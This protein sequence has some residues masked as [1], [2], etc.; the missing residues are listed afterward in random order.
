MFL[1][2]CFRNCPKDKANLFNEFFYEQ[3]SDPS[4]YDINIDLTND[5]NHNINFSHHRIRK[6]LSLIN[7]NKSPGPD[8]IHGK[9]LKN[10][11]VGLSYPLSLLFKK[12]YD[13]GSIPSEWKRAQIVPVHKKGKKENIENYRPIS[14]TSLVMKTF[15]RII[16]DEILSRTGHLLDERQH[17]F[18]KNKSCATNLIGL[19]DSLA[20]SMNEGLSTDIV[21]FDFAK[22]FD[23]VS[24]DLILKKLKLQYNIDGRL[25]RFIKNYLCDREQCVMIG[26]SKSEM[27]PVLSGVP[28]GSIIGPILFVLFIND[29]PQGL[30]PDT[31]CALYADDTKIWRTIHSTADEQIVQQDIVYL[32]NWAALNKMKFHPRKCKVMTVQNREPPL[33]GVLPEMQ[34]SYEMGGEILDNVDV[35][36]DLGVHINSKLNFNQH[37]ESKISK[38]KQQLGMVRRTCYFVNDIKRRRTLYL[39]LVR[40]Q[41]EHC[42]QIWRPTIKT[43]MQKVE[44]FQKYCVKWILSEDQVRYN[45]YSVYLRKCKELNLMPMNKLFDLNDLV[46]FHK[47]VY[48]LIP[49]KLPNYLSFFSGQTRLRSCRLDSLCIVNNLQ[50]SKFNETI[51]RKSFFFRVHTKW[52]DLPLE[53]RQI[54]DTPSFKLAVQKHMWKHV[55]DDID[56]SDDIDNFDT[57]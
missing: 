35:E 49:S 11:A 25:L 40:S 16:K 32:N 55:L 23:S 26:S 52:N 33:L 51:L 42:S 50:L 39:S 45:S 7:S 27:K 47:I 54:T 43:M 56:D 1:R 41:F 10:C 38:A 5:S 28:Q 48:E 34:C 44:N 15:E 8:A 30:S 17:G 19:C 57:V 46:L 4:A 18:L 20:I 14:L 9:I 12:S 31:N 13:T 36:K 37:C 53:I 6:L 2:G 22:A 29:L 21:Y 24:H 3:F